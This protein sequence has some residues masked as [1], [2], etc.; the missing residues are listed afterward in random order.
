MTVLISKPPLNLREEIESLRNQG[1]YSEQAFPIDDN[2]VTNGTFDSDT[3]GW[4][5]D[6]ATISAANN[7]LHVTITQAYGL[8]TQAL[9]TV[10]GK[11]YAAS[12]EVTA[13]TATHYY[14][15]LGTSSG[16]SQL[17]DSGRIN[18]AAATTTFVATTTTTYITVQSGSDTIGTSI[19]FDNI[20]VFE[21]DGTD[22]IHSLPNGWIPK[23]VFV[24]GLLKREG[25]GWDYVSYNDGTRYW[26]K[27]TVAPSATTTTTILGVRL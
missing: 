21:T 19:D 7:R 12:I 24:D 4:T 17:F 22:V 10:V 16:A 18:L 15:R 13:G 20:S 1:S 27:P 23:D 8:V 14:L 9:T 2:L 6:D 5:P 26:I 11:T 25:S 3:G